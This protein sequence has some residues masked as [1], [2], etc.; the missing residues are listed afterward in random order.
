MLYAAA[1]QRCCARRAQ[2]CVTRR[3][4]SAISAARA[5]ASSIARNASIS[6]P[7]IDK[8]VGYDADKDFTPIILI[9]D[10]DIRC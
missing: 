3:S 9:G 2:S 6:R 4:A 7:M 8:T 5:A 1:A 10:T